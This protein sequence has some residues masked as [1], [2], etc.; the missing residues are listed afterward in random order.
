MSDENIEISRRSVLGALGTIGVASGGAGL[1]TAAY[2]SDEEVFKGNHLTAGSLD[3]KLDWQEHYSD[4]SEDE[5]EFAGMADSD[6]DYV[7][8]GGSDA[9]D[10]ALNIS[11]QAGLRR[12]TAIEAY[13]D[14]DDDGVNDYS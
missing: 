2:F 4:W 12:A 7:L 13:T 6:P 14:T 1:G 9:N 11:D 3:L 8:P 5:A 10:I